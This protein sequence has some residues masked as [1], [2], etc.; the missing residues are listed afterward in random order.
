MKKKKKPLEIL[1]KVVRFYFFPQIKI[2]QTFFSIGGINCLFKHYF[3][4][5]CGP[6]VATRRHFFFDDSDR[7]RKR[8]LG[9]KLTTSRC[10]QG[11]SKDTSIP[12]EISDFIQQGDISVRNEKKKIVRLGVLSRGREK[13]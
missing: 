2:K 11:S 1:Q 13:R 3:D 4:L 10:Q 5:F 6:F 8:S 12:H 7:P 9:T